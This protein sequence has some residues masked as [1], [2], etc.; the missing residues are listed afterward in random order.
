M[1]NAFSH[2]FDERTGASAV[3]R[4]VLLEPLPGGARWRYVFGHAL[5]GTFLIQFF[6]GALLMTSYVPSSSQA[7]GSVWYINTQMAF[8]WFIRGLHHFG[9]SAMMVLLVLHLVQVVIT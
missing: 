9:S 1:R 3:F 2:W 6:T 8:G 5:F 7:W 4:S